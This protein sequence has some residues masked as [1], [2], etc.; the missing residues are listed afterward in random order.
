MDDARNGMMTLQLR[1]TIARQ[2]RTQAQDNRNCD[3]RFRWHANCANCDRSGPLA[4]RFLGYGGL[5]W[6]HFLLKRTAPLKRRRRRRLQV[7][8]KVNH[9]SAFFSLPLAQARTRTRNNLLAIVETL[10]DFAQ[11]QSLLC[12]AFVG[13]AAH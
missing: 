9:R 2:P 13:R 11:Q 3:T 10:N 5:F 7:P 12:I 8:T 6:A 1:H 4:K